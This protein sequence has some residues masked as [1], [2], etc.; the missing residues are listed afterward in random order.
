V[1]VRDQGARRDGALGRLGKLES[2]QENFEKLGK[3]TL[4]NS[5]W[6]EQNR[7]V[8]KL[9]TAIRAAWQSSVDSNVDN[10]AFA[11]ELAAL[12]NVSK[13]TATATGSEGNSTIDAVIATIPESVQ[14]SGVESL[15]TLASWFSDRLVPKIRK[16]ALLPS[17]GGFA[18]Y[19]SSAFLS[20]FLFSQVGFVQG[21]DVISTLSRA[22]WYLTHRDLESAARE[23]NQ[24]T[25]WPKILARDWLEAS[26]RHLEVR[27]ALQVAEAEAGLASLLIS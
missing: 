8:N 23:V 4:E 11:R 15:P 5:D 18:S 3:T 14:N 17:N 9:W 24:L 6:L 26:R 19:L 21:D 2:L 22:E 12:S 20:N 10:T 25:G 13:R 7:H 1:A 27:Q 16:A